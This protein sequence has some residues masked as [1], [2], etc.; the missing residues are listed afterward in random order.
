MQCDSAK[1]RRGRPKISYAR[2]RVTGHR[3][4]SGTRSPA[5]LV[6]CMLGFAQPQPGGHGSKATDATPQGEAWP[7]ILISRLELRLRHSLRGAPAGRPADHRTRVRYSRRELLPCS[8]AGLR[9]AICLF[10]AFSTAVLDRSLW[11]RTQI[12]CREGRVASYGALP[13]VLW[14]GR[15]TGRGSDGSRCSQPSR[16]QKGASRE[17]VAL[18][19]PTL[20]CLLDAIWPLLDVIKSTVIYSKAAGVVWSVVPFAKFKERSRHRD[21][22]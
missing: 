7:A 22:R 5:D 18:P 8:L 4:V 14:L 11:A 21:P 13:Q 9:Y 19:L 12:L 6:A 20:Q 17:S 1:I 3:R 2:R 15:R 10:C 16:L